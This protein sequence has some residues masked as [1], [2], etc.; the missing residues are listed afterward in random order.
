MREDKITTIEH[1]HC[2]GTIITERYLANEDH[3]VMY[4][5]QEVIGTGPLFTRYSRTCFGLDRDPGCAVA[6][7]SWSKAYKRGEM[8]TKIPKSSTNRGWSSVIDSCPLKTCL[9]HK[10]NSSYY[11]FK[12]K[13][14]PGERNTC[15]FLL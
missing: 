7:F 1:G 2:C 11:Q 12:I 4:W 15:S 8:S 13:F 3:N 9:I 14:L 6:K 10:T 5:T